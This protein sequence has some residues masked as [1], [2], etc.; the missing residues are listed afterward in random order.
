MKPHEITRAD[1]MD[2]AAYGAV[3]GEKRRALVEIK[4][5]RRVP[6]GP[7][8][9]AYFE[10]YDTMWLQ[11]HEMLHIEKG[12]EPQIADELRA[13]NPLVPNGR[14]LVATVMFEIDEPG[15]RHTVLSSLGGVENTVSLQ[16]GGE[17][18]LGQPESDI[19]RTKADG[20]TSS[21]H[22]LHFPFTP[23]Q[24]DRFRTPGT[25]VL[26]SVGHPNYGHLAVLS[27]A[28]RAELA[29]DFD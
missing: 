20:K 9:T 7:D 15:R 17:T 24:I 11:I 6:V 16:F 19:E 14:E 22:F 1:I 8:A 10:S 29:Q 23:D 18:V 2:M 13:Y 3:R 27:E 28:T 25:R 5:H 21:V 26:L 12:G 4:R